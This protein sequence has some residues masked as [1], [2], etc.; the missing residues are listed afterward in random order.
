MSTKLTIRE[1]KAQ[2][3]NM[4][5]AAKNEI[6]SIKKLPKVSYITADKYVPQHGYIKE[7]SSL[8]AISKFHKFITEQ[9]N[10]LNESLELLGITEDEL[11]EDEIKY[12]G[13]PLESWYTDIKTRLAELRQ[14]IKVK[15]LK[16]DV[17]IL[18]KNLS[19]DDKFELEMGK[20][21]IVDFVPNTQSE[22]L[23]D[24]T[25]VDVFFID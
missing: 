19:L 12:L 8:Q 15:K 16:S 18:K 4:Y 20:L 1:K 23:D 2:I 10:E 14:E 5:N 22:S 13:F 11:D 3:F 21:N 7:V 25:I 24:D 17:K 9:D 6:A